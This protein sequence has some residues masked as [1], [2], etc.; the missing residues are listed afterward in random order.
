MGKKLIQKSSDGSIDIAKTLARPL[1]C[2]KNADAIIPTMI[3]ECGVTGGRTIQAYKR[4][5]KTE[6][7]ERFI[8]QGVSAVVWLFGVKVLNKV[9]DWFGKNILKLPDL[10]VDAGVDALRQPFNNVVK[11]K[12]T[13]TSIFKFSKIIF[14]CVATCLFM[15]AILPKIIHKITNKNL[16]KDKASENNAQNSNVDK[17][18]QNN[19]VSQSQNTNQTK[20][21][22]LTLMND[23]L[24]EIKTN[25]NSSPSFKG[26]IAETLLKI[27]DNLENNNKWRLMSTD[28]GVVLGRTLNG[29]NKYE[30]L[31]FLFRDTTSIYFYMFATPHIVKLL[32]KLAGNTD[33]HPE[34]LLEMR[35]HLNSAL[36]NEGG[37]LTSAEFL[38]K[39]IGKKGTVPDGFFNPAGKKA[40][41]VI[42][43]DDFVEKMGS[44][45]SEAQ[46][47]KLK[48]MTE[49][50]PI[51]DGKRV[52]T[53]M[54][55]EDALS[56]GGWLTDPKFIKKA[57]NK[58]T[59][60]RSDNIRKFVSIEKLEN[61][62]NSFD[63]FAQNIAKYADKH[64]SGVVTEEIIK[65]A[66]NSNV[67]KNLSFIVLG[68]AFSIFG[69]AY[70]IPKIQYKITEKLTGSKAFPGT[71]N[72]DD[73]KNKKA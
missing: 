7:R 64:N 14:S 67:I 51:A 29:R 1:R 47:E 11:N 36:Q 44:K 65:K 6:G 19:T 68:T 63:S 71:M 69:L 48:G 2:F 18:N 16:E 62:R 23:F 3:I 37:K 26:G 52:L 13:A 8:E 54:Q 56:E 20:N 15:G 31:E 35:E 70:L 45:L 39:A 60:G 21:G 55:I 12:K 61:I 5:G 42:G 25:K 50:Q 28:T 40:L 57:L 33:I 17:Q 53:K 9:G 58:A 72:Y 66:S 46:I 24:N 38:E 30:S 41:K 59:F 10:D 27:T 43:F 73:D 32:N 4:G 34:A 22:S 49:L